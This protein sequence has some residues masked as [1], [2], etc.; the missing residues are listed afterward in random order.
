[1]GVTAR[2]KQ[3]GPELHPEKTKLV[4]CKDANRKESHP[5]EQFDFLGYTFRPRAAV[6]RKGK[7]FCSFSPAISKKAVQKICDEIRRSDLHRPHD[8]AVR[9]SPWEPCESRGS[10]TVLEGPRD[11][12]PRGYLTTAPCI[13]PQGL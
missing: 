1:M 8:S 12:T 7:L 4:Y 6:N 9:F 5:N 11:E 3:C 13:S 10:R 2:L